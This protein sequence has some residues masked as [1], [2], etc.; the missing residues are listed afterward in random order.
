MSGRARVWKHIIC[1]CGVFFAQ[2]VAFLLQLLDFLHQ[3]GVILCQSCD[4]LLQRVHGLS[5]AA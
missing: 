3:N 4:F 1:K 5:G 2:I